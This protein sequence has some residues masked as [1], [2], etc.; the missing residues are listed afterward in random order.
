MNNIQAYAISVN[1]EIVGKLTRYPEKEMEFDWDTL[2]TKR[3]NF[4]FYMDE[5]NNE[6]IVT[7]RDICIITADGGVI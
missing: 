1:H 6:Y 3:G 2:E 5:A 7:K 4:K